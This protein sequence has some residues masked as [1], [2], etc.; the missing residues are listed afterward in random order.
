MS[1]TDEE[2]DKLFGEASNK[3]VFEYK[4]E[5]WNDIEKQLPIQK[6]RKRAYWWWTANVFFLGF[7]GLIVFDASKKT[8]GVNQ[9]NTA[10]TTNQKSSNPSIEKGVKMN[11]NSA[12]QNAKNELKKNDQL[13]EINANSDKKD[14]FDL[15]IND[16]F[17]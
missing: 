6:K 14:N 17:F 10:S 3:Q 12:I 9:V 4:P 7:L 5:Y 8:N 16:F 11:V 2:I 15:I 13:K 1:W